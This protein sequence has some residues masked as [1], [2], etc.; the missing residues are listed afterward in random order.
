MYPTEIP[1]HDEEEI[2]GI[3]TLKFTED[4]HT[5]TRLTIV[6][7]TLEDHTFSGHETIGIGVM[8]R[9]SK[10]G[11]PQKLLH[12]DVYLLSTRDEYSRDSIV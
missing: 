6:I 4:T 8:C 2:L 10:I 5:G 12:I 3:F 1:R 11:I 7:F 9:L